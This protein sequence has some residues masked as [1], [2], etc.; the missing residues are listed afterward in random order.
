LIKEALS[1]GEMKGNVKVNKK[2]DPIYETCLQWANEW[3]QERRK[4]RNG[5]LLQVG[6]RVQEFV[7]GWKGEVVG[8]RGE[9]PFVH[10]DYFSE[11]RQQ[12]Y[13]RRLLCKITEKG[14]CC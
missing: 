8:F 9:F 11:G 13:C 10:W 7:T 6:D 14:Y 3:A 2:G 12:S 1:N 4:D 5:N